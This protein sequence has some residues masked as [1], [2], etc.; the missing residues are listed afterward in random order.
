MPAPGVRALHVRTSGRRSDPRTSRSTAASTSGPCGRG[1]RGDRRTPGPRCAPRRPCHAPG[2]LEG[3]GAE[4]PV[5]RRRLHAGARL[6]SAHGAP[7]TWSRCPSGSG[8]GRRPNDPGARPARRRGHSSRVD[9]TGTNQV[10]LVIGPGI[11]PSGSPVAVRPRG[12]AAADRHPR[13]GARTGTGR[14]D[15]VWRPAA[16][17]TGCWPPTAGWPGYSRRAARDRLLV[18]GGPLERLTE[19]GGALDQL[20][21]ADGP[22]ERLLASRARWTGSPGPAA[23]WTGCWWRRGCSTGC[24]PRTAS[25]K[26][27]PPTVAPSTSS[28][29]SAGIADPAPDRRALALIPDLHRSV[30]TLNRSVGPPAT[31]RTGSGGGRRPALEA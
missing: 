21:A 19:R 16:P 6:G 9:P 7:A 12:R 26:S 4:G 28:S 29:G 8:G 13:R 20:V 30:D 1:P 10:M 27:S 15:R 3:R 24:C 22:L 23:P 5:G 25:W 18:Q 17:S 2:V 11:S 14:W 31:S